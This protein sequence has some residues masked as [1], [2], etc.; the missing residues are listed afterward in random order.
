MKPCSCPACTAL[1]ER[2]RNDPQLLGLCR[3]KLLIRGWAGRTDEVERV[4]ILAHA[5]WAQ[6]AVRKVAGKGFRPTKRTTQTALSC[7]VV[8][9]DLEGETPIPMVGILHVREAVA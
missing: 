7:E 6:A 5:E 8:S 4:Y 3:A 2:Y 9:Q 1:A